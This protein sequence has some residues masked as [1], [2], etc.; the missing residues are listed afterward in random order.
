MKRS[1]S[2]VNGGKTPPKPLFWTIAETATFLSIGTRTVYDL[3]Y[4]GELPRIEIGVPGSKKPAV[5]IPVAA[6]EAYAQKVID[7]SGA[8]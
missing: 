5:R 2:P 6:V 3:I 7:A 1:A 8:A 4:A